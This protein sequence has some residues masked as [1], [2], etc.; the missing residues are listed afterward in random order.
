VSCHDNC[1]NFGTEAV[2]DI[3]KKNLSKNKKTKKQQYIEEALPL[4][5][6]AFP[7]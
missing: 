1:A 6:R 4:E 3:L 5:V 2:K 7:R